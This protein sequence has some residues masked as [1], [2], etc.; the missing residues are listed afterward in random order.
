MRV[1]YGR[2]GPGPEA[3]KHGKG[4]VPVHRRWPRCR[5]GA[6][7][8]G[9]RGSPAP[10]APS[11]GPRDRRFLGPARPRGGREPLPR[12]ERTGGPP[13]DR[14][15]VPC[16]ARAQ[17]PA[18]RGREAPRPRAPQSTPDADRRRRAGPNAVQRFKG[19]RSTHATSL[20]PR[21]FRSSAFKNIYIYYSFSRHFPGGSRVTVPN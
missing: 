16:T 20:R 3:G 13:L 4:L 5:L 9:S 2:S 11:P 14:A 10:G 19:P 18:P 15:R 21:I 7:A 12:R 8:L 17:G 1:G 6:A